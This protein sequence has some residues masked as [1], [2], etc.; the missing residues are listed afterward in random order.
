MLLKGYFHGFRCVEYFYPNPINSNGMISEKKQSV[1]LSRKNFT[2]ENVYSKTCEIL[3]ISQNEEEKLLHGNVYSKTC[4]MVNISQN[5][6]ETW[7]HSRQFFEQFFRKRGR[8]FRAS[9]SMCLHFAITFGI[10]R[11]R[12]GHRCKE[13]GER[14]PLLGYS[15]PQSGRYS[16]LASEKITMKRVATKDCS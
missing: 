4:K 1:M 14:V 12:R 10:L 13:V 7:L 6:E 2:R 11:W 16:L 3:N 15:I 8:L 9:W 5:P